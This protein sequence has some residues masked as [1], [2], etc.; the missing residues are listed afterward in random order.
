M[1]LRIFSILGILISSWLLVQKATGSITYLVGCG[2]S[3][4]CANVLGSRW[5][6]WFLIPVAAL[7]LVAY[8]ALLFLTFRPRKPAMAAIGTCLAG[9]AVWFACVQVFIL[10]HFCRWC[11]AAHL[12]GL[13]CATLIFRKSLV[14]PREG[15]GMGLAAGVMAV[16][17][18]I[19]GQVFGPVPET[20]AESNVV[21]PKGESVAN[22]DTGPIHERGKGRTITLLENKIYN[23]ATLPHVGDPAAPHVVVKYFDYA[24]NA[25]RD[26]HEDLNQFMKAHPGQLCV[27]LLPCPIN[28]S[29]NPNLPAHLEDH[30]HAC[31]L[32]RLAMA[33]WRTDPRSFEAVHHALFARPVLDEA[34]A[35]AAVKPLLAKPLPTGAVKD[36]WIDELLAAD[37]EDYKR[38]NLT[39]S[40]Q[41]N[42][43]MPKLLVGG[44]RML[45]GVTKSRE[46]LF[47]AL[48]QEFKIPPSVLPR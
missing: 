7:S 14:K 8:G 17:V 22:G 4:G 15:T 25:C 1:A 46:I 30:A 10:H 43:L 42:Y 23:I 39:N 5:S 18:M 34:A 41:M 28:R 2:A 48:E 45:H 27:V 47:R 20:H 29:C 3:S 19:V 31:E 12:I 6:Q 11:L 38:I 33:C 36:P 21:I 16:A 13:V 35:M 32:A 40:G 9:A 37:S 24:C 44:T 26:M